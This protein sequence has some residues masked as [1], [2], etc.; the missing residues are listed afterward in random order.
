VI[1]A[2]AASRCWITDNLTT[3]NG[4]AVTELNGQRTTENGQ[5]SVMATR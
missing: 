5:L 3:D 4:E 2:E 1:R